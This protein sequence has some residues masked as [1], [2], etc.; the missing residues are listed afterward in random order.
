M[1]KRRKNLKAKNMGKGNGAYNVHSGRGAFVNPHNQYR[2]MG[3][4]KKRIPTEKWTQ[5]ILAGM[6]GLM[7]LG[8][9]AKYCTTIN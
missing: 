2:P 8:S 9:L 6:V 7:S 4:P 1:T 5:W 3:I